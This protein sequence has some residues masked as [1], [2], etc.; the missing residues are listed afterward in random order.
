MSILN[1]EGMRNYK[2]WYRKDWMS[3]VMNKEEPG[4][5]IEEALWKISYQII[6]VGVAQE[7]RLDCWAIKNLVVELL[8]VRHSVLD[9]WIVLWLKRRDK[10]LRKLNRNSKKR[11]NKWWSMREKCR[12]SETKTKK[13]WEK[14]NKRKSR[15]NK[16]CS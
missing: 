14:K 16:S 5:L 2:F 8:W 9:Q 11:L 1:R 13:K 6:V 7:S 4:R 3:S 12:K 15:D 10:R